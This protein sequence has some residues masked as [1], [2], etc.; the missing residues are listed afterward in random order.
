MSNPRSSPEFKAE[1]VRQANPD[2]TRRHRHLC[3]V[4]GRRHKSRRISHALPVPPLQS[5]F[6][7]HPSGVRRKRG[8]GWRRPVSGLLAL[9]AGGVRCHVVQRSLQANSFPGTHMGVAL[10]CAGQDD[11]LC[12]LARDA[13]DGAHRLKPTFIG[14][15]QGIIENERNPTFL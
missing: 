7:I 9:S 1:A 14:G 15:T 10:R 11:C 6:S 3:N 2:R 8:D 4:G 5:S 12:I 13:Q